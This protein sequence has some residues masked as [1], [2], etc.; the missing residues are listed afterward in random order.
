MTSL[1]SPLTFGRLVLPNRIVMSPMTRSR[2]LGNIPNAMMAT[3]YSQRATAGLILTEGTSPSPNGLGYAR[4]PGLYSPEQI[5]GWRLV[6]DAVHTAGGR[7]FVQLMHV[8]RVGHPHNLPAGARLVGASAVAAPGTMYTDVAGPQP[9]PAPAAMTEH[10]IREATDEFVHAARSAIAAGLDGIELHGANGYLLEQFLGTST[11][12]RDDGYGGSIAGRSRFVLEVA[13][14]AADAIGADRV[15]IRLSPYGVFNGMTPD[16]AT[17]ELFA[18]LASELSK[19]GLVHLHVV[20]HAAI[21]A[22]PVSETL[23]A[24]L[25]AS[26]QQAYIM[27]GGYDRSRAEADLAAGKGDLVA[28]GRPYLANPGLVGKLERG[29]ELRAP[30]PA[31]FYTPGEQGYVDWAVD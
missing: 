1:F 6:S 20:D 26:F 14:A 22:P 25:R 2:A 23:K 5:A 18:H 30:D 3:Y 19:L 9:H 31:T 27:S 21:G 13:R 17:D 4:I 12:Q 7:I 8:G 11:N 29:A 10:D 24:T 28:F 16:A 15:G